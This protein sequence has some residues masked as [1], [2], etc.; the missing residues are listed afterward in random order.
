MYRPM[1]LCHCHYDQ[2]RYDR[3]NDQPI[4]HLTD[5]GILCFA[6]THPGSSCPQLCC[7][8][9]RYACSICAGR[10]SVHGLCRPL[11]ISDSA[12]GQYFSD[13][14]FCRHRRNDRKQRRRGQRLV[15]SSYYTALCKLR[16]CTDGCPE[17]AVKR[18]ALLLTK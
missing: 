18:A 3:R 8:G 5:P 1:L 16:V 14:V 17:P 11:C 2:Q 9:C 6:W 12:I 13:I 4:L 15:G 7:L 10:A